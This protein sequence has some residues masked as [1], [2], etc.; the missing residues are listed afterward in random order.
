[1]A[2][3]FELHEDGAG[4][5]RFRLKSE[6]GRAIASSSSVDAKRDAAHNGTGS[7]RVSAPAAT[8]LDQTA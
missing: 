6:S 2:G 4:V 3:E 1:M 7:V 8:L 5:S